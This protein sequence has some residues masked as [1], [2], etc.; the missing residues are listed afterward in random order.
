MSIS[1]RLPR[2][3][4]EVGG[5]GRN[6]GWGLQGDWGDTPPKQG[7]TPTCHYLEVRAHRFK[8]GAENHPPNGGR[9]EESK[10]EKANHRTTERE[11]NS[12]EEA[13]RTEG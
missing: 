3:A 12:G 11:N 6:R 9:K 10:N 8:G 7:G 4:S 5:K 1:R 13:L 2:L